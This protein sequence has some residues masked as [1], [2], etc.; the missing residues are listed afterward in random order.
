MTRKNEDGP[1]GDAAREIVDG[2]FKNGVRV[3][4]RAAPESELAELGGRVTNDLYRENTKAWGGI[5]K[6]DELVRRGKSATRDR[7][8][9][10]RG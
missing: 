7:G 9:R 4:G 1:S 3:T 5:M 2:L 8:T 6:L 10:D